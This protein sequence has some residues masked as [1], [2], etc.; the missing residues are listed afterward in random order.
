M[1][2]VANLPVVNYKSIFHSVVSHRTDDALKGE[3]RLLQHT[4]YSFT[5]LSIASGSRF[6]NKAALE[7]NSTDRM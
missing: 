4:D 6:Q 1:L 2:V 3:I 5:I 7:I